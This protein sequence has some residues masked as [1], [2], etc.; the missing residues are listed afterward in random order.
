MSLYMRPSENPRR[1]VPHFPSF[2]WNPRVLWRNT[3][4]ATSRIPSR[5]RGGDRSACILYLDEGFNWEEQDLEG[6]QTQH[7]NQDADAKAHEMPCVYR[8]AVIIGA[9]VDQDILQGNFS[10]KPGGVERSRGIGGYPHPSISRT[11]NPQLRR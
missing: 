7:G 6:D 1:T 2:S 8:S 5:R 9:G 3:G 10:G 11:T 4:M